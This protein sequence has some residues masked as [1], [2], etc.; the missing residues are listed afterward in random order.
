MHD[1]RLPSCLISWLLRSI[2]FTP[3]YMSL[4]V[5]TLL[6]TF[7]ACHW[8]QQHHPLGGMAILL[9]FVAGHCA[10]SKFPIA[11]AKVP[12]SSATAFGADVLLPFGGLL[13]LLLDGW[14]FAVPTR[15]QNSRV[16]HLYNSQEHKQAPLIAAQE[17]NAN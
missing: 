6:E 7:L 3:G 16:S 9:W 11:I 1:S 4:P 8:R 15:S 17:A 10:C 14:T 2:N 13:L 5:A 12:K